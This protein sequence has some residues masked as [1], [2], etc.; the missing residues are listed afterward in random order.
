MYRRWAGFEGPDPHLRGKAD[1]DVASRKVSILRQW[2]T[3][4]MV[5]AIRE[6]ANGFCSL[7]EPEAFWSVAP[8][9]G[10]NLRHRWILHC[11]Q[12]R[13]LCNRA[14]PAYRGT[15]QGRGRVPKPHPKMPRALSPAG[16]YYDRFKE[17]T[18]PGTTPGIVKRLLPPRQ[19]RGFSRLKQFIESG[20]LPK[21]MKMRLLEVFHCGSRTHVVR[22]YL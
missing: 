18:R 13:G 12:L 7:R 14:A 4:P 6:G 15:L 8:Q 17:Q 11:T 22:T 16:S 19:S 21:H 2:G 20:I 1:I 9:R 3:R 5:W 10:L